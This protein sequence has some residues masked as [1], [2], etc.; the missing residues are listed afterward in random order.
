MIL[1]LWIVVAAFL[2]NGLLLLFSESYNA[3]LDVLRKKNASELDER[4]LSKKARYFQSRYVSGFY[5]T[6]VGVIC[7]VLLWFTL[8]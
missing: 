6:S 1:F 8:K 2:L 3:K 4:L 7:L 5:F